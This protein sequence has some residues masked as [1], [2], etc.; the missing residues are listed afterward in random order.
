MNHQR[1]LGVLYLSH[2]E[3]GLNLQDP[4]TKS[5]VF[6][7]KWLCQVL[8][9]DDSSIESFLVNSLIGTHEKIKGLRILVSSSAYDKKIT[10]DFY[11][12]AVEN[13]RRLDVKIYPKDI[14]PIR[15][16]WIYNSQILTDSNGLCFKPPSR[17]PAYAQNFSVTCQSQSTQENSEVCTEV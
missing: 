15:R 6:R 17:F 8:Q 16:H 14:Q 11:K 1:E 5:E 10:N 13:F 12:N 3:G 9:S 4:D 7:I 2:A